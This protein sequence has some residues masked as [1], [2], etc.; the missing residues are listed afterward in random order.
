M[1]DEGMTRLVQAFDKI[2]MMNQLNKMVYTEFLNLNI[3]GNLMKNN[4][5]K[6]FAKLLESFNGI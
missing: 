2:N 3:S 5:I 6:P 4:S 1:T